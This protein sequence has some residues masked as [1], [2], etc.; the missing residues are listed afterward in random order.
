MQW[1]SISFTWLWNSC[2]HL[3]PFPEVTYGWWG[4]STA[5]LTMAGNVPFFGITQHASCCV[6]TE[7][8][9][10]FPAPL[11]PVLGVTSGSLGSFTGA[12][13]PHWTSRKPKGL[14]AWMNLILLKK[15]HSGANAGTLSNVTH[16]SE[17][18]LCHS[19]LWAE[20]FGIGLISSQAWAVSLNLPLLPTV[21]DS[22]T[23]KNRESCFLCLI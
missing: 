17:I 20:K 3:L 23:V 18:T 14:S 8:P 22:V 7:Y 6:C 13:K 16:S 5:D 1:Q 2:P 4:H 11:Y 10:L 15:N 19:Y 12:P 9:P 21:L